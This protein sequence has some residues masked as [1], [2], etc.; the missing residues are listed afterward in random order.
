MSV[1]MAWFGYNLI[2]EGV[3][4]AST[5]HGWTE[6]EIEDAESEGDYIPDHVWNAYLN[7]ESDRDRNVDSDEST[8]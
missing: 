2:I 6:E 8:D 4:M 1:L 3:K 7:R 5:Y